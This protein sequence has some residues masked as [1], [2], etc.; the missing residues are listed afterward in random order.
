MVA[1]DGCGD[2]EAWFGDLTQTNRFGLPTALLRQ[3]RDF[4]LYIHRI[5]TII[6]HPLY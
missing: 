4:F 1:Y 5:S 6:R 2:V 3:D